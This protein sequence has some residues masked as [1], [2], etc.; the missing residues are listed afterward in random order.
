MA[1]KK[2]VEEPEPVVELPP[3]PEPGAEEDLITA[4]STGLE[5]ALRPQ[6]VLDIWSADGYA[7]QAKLV[8]KLLGIDVS[9]SIPARRDIICD[10]HLFTLI[11]VKALCLSRRQAAS[12][13]AIMAKVLA[14]ATDSNRQKDCSFKASA[15]AA[16]CFKE[17]QR[18]LLNHTVNNPPECLD[19]FNASEAKQLADFATTTFFKHFLLYK[20]CC[21]HDQDGQVLHFCVGLQRPLPPPDLSKAKDRPG[22][23]SKGLSEIGAA[24]SK[25][26][27]PD[28]DADADASAT[29]LSDE[30][31]I[32]R[33]VQEK[34]RETEARL[35]AKLD[36]REEALQQKLAEKASKS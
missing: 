12:F 27:G 18:L 11:H 1:P 31:E 30:E 9:C 8:T 10:F 36:A 34:L 15:D 24:Y 14:M 7:Q 3:E 17:F 33:L 2:I 19:V 26:R 16:T 6:D 25:D 4:L 32:E 20:F 21:S 22:R 35:Q 13:H 5:L 28:Q 29:A 23:R